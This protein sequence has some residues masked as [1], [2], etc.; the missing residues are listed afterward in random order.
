MTINERIKLIRINN[1]LNQMQ[2]KKI[3]DVTQSTISQIEQ[4][5]ISPSLSVLL[6]IIEK[7][8]IDANW[9]LTG[10]ENINNTNIYS[11]NEPEEKN[12]KNDDNLKIKIEYME[13]EINLLREQLEM[14]NQIIDFL[15]NK[16]E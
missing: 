11:I 16:K 1:K 14:K 7:F 12:N 6:K 8:N 13:K 15:K 3:I 2:F 5:I 4:G 10:K 9:L